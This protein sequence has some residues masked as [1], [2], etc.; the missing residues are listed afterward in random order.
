M[1]HNSAKNYSNAMLLIIVCMLKH[2]PLTFTSIG[3]ISYRRVQQNTN[4]CFTIIKRCT[5]AMMY[6][7]RIIW[8]FI[9]NTGKAYTHTHGNMNNHVALQAFAFFP[10]FSFNA[11]WCSF[12]NSVNFNSVM[13]QSFD[14]VVQSFC[15]L[16]IFNWTYL[17]NQFPYFSNTKWKYQEN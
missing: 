1:G 12:S 14:I 15:S 17:L 4:I 7:N 2:T 3:N 5:Y 10:F 6:T 16:C 11:H 8:N 13:D 9:T